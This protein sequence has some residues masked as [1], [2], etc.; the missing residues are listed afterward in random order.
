MRD[1]TNLYI[2]LGQDGLWAPMV[3][4]LEPAPATSIFRKE[5]AIWMVNC[6]FVYY[7][8][9]LEYH[10]PSSSFAGSYICILR[11]LK[12]SCGFLNDKTS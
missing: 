12:C 3:L 10:V 5:R 8:Y 7:C 1:F 9:V 2:K 6:W 11:D 4:Y